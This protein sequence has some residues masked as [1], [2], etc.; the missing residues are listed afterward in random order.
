MARM[1]HYLAFDLGA[2]SGR[3]ILGSRGAKLQ[4]EELH[5]FPNTPVRVSRRCTGTRC[6]SGTRSSTGS[7]WPRASESCSSTGIGIDT[8]GVD[9]A[10]LGEDGM[11]VDNPRHYR[12]PRTNGM[13]E[14]LFA[15]V[16]RERSIRLHR[17]P[18]HADQHA[19]PVVRHEAGGLAGAG[20]GAQL[21]NMPD[22]FNYWLTGVAQSEA[23]HRQHVAVLQ[24][25]DHDAG[26]RSCSSAWTCP[27]EILARSW[28]RRERCSARCRRAARPGVRH[29]RP[30]HRLRGGGGSRGGGDNWCYISS[31]TW[32]LMGM[33]IDAPVINEQSLA[34]E[35]HQRGR[36]RR[37]DPAAEEYR[38][39]VA[40]AGVPPRVGCRK[41]AEY[42]YEQLTQ[43]GGGG[44]AVRA[45]PSI[46]TRSWSPATCRRRSRRTAARPGRRAPATHGEYARA[47]LESLGAALSPGAG[48]P[49]GAGQ[50]AESK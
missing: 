26:P 13:M 15:V 3:A 30:R 29:R 4:L 27:R 18:V 22:L 8:W 31:G 48:E 10:L 34:A 11:L 38:R 36:R 12:D 37:Q 5:R 24:S 6:G 23:D 40:A 49:G 14:K 35:L 2:E 39:A 47:I 21:L 46:P 20:R 17:H 25:R 33:E 41:A 50:A 44:A 16:P 32:S 28:P 42:S 45:D 9:F 43:H 7:R 19:V 1:Q